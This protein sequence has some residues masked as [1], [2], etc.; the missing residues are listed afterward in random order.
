MNHL[1]RMTSGI[2]L[3]EVGKY[4]VFIHPPKLHDRLI[5]DKIEKD[6]YEDCFLA[7]GL[8]KETDIEL[9]ESVG[10]W[11]SKKEE[12]LKSLE[13]KIE[14]AKIDYFQGY[15]IQ[16]KRRHIK[17]NLDLW[18][19]QYKNLLVKKNTY[20]DKTCEHASQ[21]AKIC[22]LISRSSFIDEKPADDFL[23]LQKI[24][25]AYTESILDESEIREI[26]K[27]NEWRI[28]WNISKNNTNLFA[29]PAY[30]LTSEQLSLISWSRFYENIHESPDCPSEEIIQDDIA[31]DG[32]MIHQSRKRKEE[33]KIRE[34]EK[35]L[36]QNAKSGADLF[37][38]VRNMQEQSQILSLNDGHGKAALNSLRNDLSQHGQMNEIDLT[39]VRQK[40]QMEINRR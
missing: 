25:S 9:A 16:A 40:I 30:E 34:A 36:P 1:N 12:E 31:V 11:D 28:Y 35:L 6:V 22:Y 5:S 17:F 8:T 10:I 32:W 15:S 20:Y 26:A 4:Q 21:Y 38:P 2:I 23:S 33:Q 3:L 13:D 27:S 39:H 19:E 7:G 37:L 18:Q 14:N 29:N 24:V